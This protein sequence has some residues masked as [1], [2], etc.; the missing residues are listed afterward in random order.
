MKN[1]TEAAYRRGDLFER[2]GPHFRT[3]DA[4]LSKQRAAPDVRI[5][6]RDIDDVPS[7]LETMRNSGLV[8]SPARAV[9]GFNS[10]L[11]SLAICILKV[12]LN[13]IGPWA[14]VGDVI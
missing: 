12:R 6:F 14:F 8:P 10:Q 5:I 9:V 13:V 3:C 4:P 2:R 11:V 7:V 1:K